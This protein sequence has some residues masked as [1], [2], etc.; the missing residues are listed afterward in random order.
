[1]IYCD[2][3]Y[4]DTQVLMLIALKG[5]VY[6]YFDLRDNK[7][8]SLL[9]EY[10]KENEKE[11]FASYAIHAEITALLRC[12][13]AV[14]NMRCIDLM[15]ESRMITMSHKKYFTQDG[16]LLGQV[17][18]LLGKDV[19]EDK[20][21]KEEMR[22]LILSKNSWTEEEWE[23]IMIYCYSDI[24]ELRSL[25]KKI[26]DIHAD[27]NHPYKLAD[28]LSRGEYVRMSAE[29]DFA[30][31]G[32]PV[33]GG[34][35]E[36]IF[37]NKD[38]VKTDIIQSLPL[39]WRLC[40]EKTKDNNWTQKKK[41]I[42]E[43]I[44]IRGWTEWKRTDTGLP[45]LKDEY[46]KELAL[47]I[48]EVGVLRTAIK[49]LNTLNSADLR[50]QVVDGY[51]KPK[52]FAFTAV[53]G[54]NG[55]KPT[56]GYLLNL[57]AWLRRVINPHPGMY[58]AGYDW[59][60]QEIAVAAALSGDQKLLEAYQTGDIYLAL[61]KM[62]GH[63][64]E[65]GTKKTHKKQRDLFK[66]LQLG[67]GYGKGVNSL[68]YDIW[69]IMQE[70]GMSL[71][72]AKTKAHEIFTWHKRTF[73]TYWTW[74][75]KQIR[76]ARMNG[77]IESIDGWVEWV[78]RMTKDTQL[79]NFPSQANGAVMLRVATKK[80]YHAWK[81]GRIPPLLCSQHDAVWF[82][83]IFSE[84]TKIAAEIFEIMAKSS[85]EVIGIFVK[86]DE[87]LF[88]MGN[89]YIPDNYDQNHAN[90]WSLAIKTAILPSGAFVD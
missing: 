88:G 43:L 13:I 4:N 76:Q 52:T 27:Y 64:P 48:P 19:T 56:A 73:S 89:D 78:D 82:N 12:G 28:L 79:K 57:P 26:I 69:G 54:R 46:L 87:K 30:S 55:L 10:L 18:C 32:F 24:S 7:D 83:V 90:I 60:Q 37:G 9:E 85:I 34:A 8:K 63:I 20:K 86:S 5:D 67:L 68:G 80:I 45:V 51:I 17:R 35:V 14:D 25:Y 11:I 22:E 36:T 66:A 53:T 65:S 3:E 16:T 23:S 40:Y 31:Q 81:E 59:S 58:F 29:M 2:T 61:G 75:D 38:K 62:S 21:Q 72:D 41:E 1:M 77:W 74:N 84:Q 44:R 47:I 15:A 49:S 39:Y 71:L 50:E 33:Y 42:N 70:D 6:S